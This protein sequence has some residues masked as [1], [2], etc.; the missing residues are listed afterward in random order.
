MFFKF[1]VIKFYHRKA[2]KYLESSPLSPKLTTLKK[3]ATL[4]LII[5]YASAQTSLY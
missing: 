4:K 3:S 5:G 2:K 1:K